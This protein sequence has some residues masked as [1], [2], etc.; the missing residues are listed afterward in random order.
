MASDMREDL[1]SPDSDLSYMHRRRMVCNVVIRG[2]RIG[3]ERSARLLV[4]RVERF[5]TRPVGIVGGLRGGRLRGDKDGEE[6]S[7]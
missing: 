6:V 7:E 2:S 5:S 4:R 3:F 1:W